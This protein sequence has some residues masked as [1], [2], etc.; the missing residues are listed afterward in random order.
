[1]EAYLKLLLSDPYSPPTDS[2]L[3]GGLLKVLM[4]EGKVV[5]VS[6]TVVYPASVYEEMK[7]KVMAHFKAHDKVT[8]GQVRDMFETSR[9][10][11]LAFLEHLDQQRITRRVGDERILR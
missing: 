11:A 7:E 9:K 4:D 1:M 10:Y 6:D 8:V 2:P 5:K 3:D